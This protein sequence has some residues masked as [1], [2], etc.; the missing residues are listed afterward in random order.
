[1]K[2]GYVY[3]GRD[4]QAFRQLFGVRNAANVQPIAAQRGLPKDASPQVTEDASFSGL[5]A[6]S[7]VSWRE[8]KQSDWEGDAHWQATVKILEILAGLYGDENVRL[9]VWFED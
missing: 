4:Y 7:W 9:V 5:Y 1:M 2:L 3:L 8:L 6:H